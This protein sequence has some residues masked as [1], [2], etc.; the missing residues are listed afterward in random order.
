MINN[1]FTKLIDDKKSFK[2]FN[3]LTDIM[4]YTFVH[5]LN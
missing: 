3:S 5:Y 1:N 2:Y 4:F